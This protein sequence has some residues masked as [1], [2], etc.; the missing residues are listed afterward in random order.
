MLVLSVHQC[1]L[2]AD[3]PRAFVEA[4]IPLEEL[5]GIAPDS[6]K[7]TVI[8]QACQQFQPAAEFHGAASRHDD[9]GHNRLLSIDLPV[10]PRP[11]ES[12]RCA[13]AVVAVACPGS[14]ALW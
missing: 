4:E 3:E 9:N 7:S 8:F 2:Q 12:H 13:D 1:L 6:T 11:D 10:N 14:G 5:T